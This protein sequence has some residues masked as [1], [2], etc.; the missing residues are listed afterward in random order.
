MQSKN[1]IASCVIP[2]KHL[3]QSSDVTAEHTFV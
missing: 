2:L 1:R 3:R